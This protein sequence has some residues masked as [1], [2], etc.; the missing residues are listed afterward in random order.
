LAI[1]NIVVAFP[2]APLIKGILSDDDAFDV[3]LLIGGDIIGTGGTLGAS[4][5]FQPALTR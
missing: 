4:R 5:P 1:I 3:A 2:D